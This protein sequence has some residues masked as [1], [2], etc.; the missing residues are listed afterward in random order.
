MK[1]R[2]EYWRLR[3][4]MYEDR[5][6]ERY[7]RGM[8][9]GITLYSDDIKENKV[10]IDSLIFKIKLRVLNK[11]YAT[12]TF[13]YYPFDNKIEKEIWFIDERDRDMAME[14]ISEEL[15]NG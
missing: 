14:F 15:R 4:D 3:K 10:L 13:R 6:K 12:K 7:I 8:D 11:C 9:D 1:P 5:Y 2:I